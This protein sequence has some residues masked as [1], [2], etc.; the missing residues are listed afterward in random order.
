MYYHGTARK[1]NIGQYLLPPDDHGLEISE[2][3]R[4]KNLDLV[5]FTKDIGSAKIYAG[6]A[7]NSYGGLPRI[8]EVEPV[9]KIEII[10]STPGTTVFA[11]HKAIIIGEIAM[12][13]NKLIKLI[14]ETVRD[15]MLSDDLEYSSKILDEVIGIIQFFNEQANSRIL[16]EA[17]GK[18]DYVKKTLG[19]HIQ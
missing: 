1:F 10:Q 6:R 15:E 18:L 5:F 4:R 17:I 12:N 16:G 14:Q 7:K 11:A 19:D 9:G 8:Y 13:E 3:G 2:R